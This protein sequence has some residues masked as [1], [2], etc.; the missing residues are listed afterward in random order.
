MGED[1]GGGL[2]VLNYLNVLN[3]LRLIAAAAVLFRRI[4]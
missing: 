2:N 4:F 1:E 3:E